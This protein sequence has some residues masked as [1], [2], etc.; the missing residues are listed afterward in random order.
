MKIILVAGARPNFMKLESTSLNKKNIT[1]AHCVVIVTHHSNWD[2]EWIV[3][4]ARCI[5]D[6][7]NA[8]QAVSGKKDHVFKL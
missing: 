8:T 7:R 3:N 4:H 1:D 2:Y 5:V 6:T